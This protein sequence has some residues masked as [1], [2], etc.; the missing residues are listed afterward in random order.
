MPSLPIQH[1][2]VAGLFEPLHLW[3]RDFE[4][5]PTAP[6]LINKLASLKA[7]KSNH[8]DLLTSIYDVLANSYK[9]DNKATDQSIESHAHACYQYEIG[10]LDISKDVLCAMPI[11]LEAGMSDIVIGQD[12]VD[13]LTADEQR[14]FLQL[15]NGHFNQD[16]WEF[17]VSDKGNWFL[18]LPKNTKPNETI[19]IQDALGASLRGLVEGNEDIQWSQQLN[20]LQMLLF[21]S[22]TNQQREQNRQRTISSFWLWD[23]NITPVSISNT[24]KSHLE[25]MVG[26]GYEGQ[27]IANTYHIDWNADI[28]YEGSQKTGS[29]VYIYNDL[30]LLASRNDLEGWQQKLS[31]IEQSLVALLDNDAMHTI[32]YGGRALSW[33]SLDK[34]KWRFFSRRKKTLLELI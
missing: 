8:Q 31:E 34:N 20:E 15:L 23:V 19:P 24:S 10:E 18:L 13:D 7:R 2:F 16:G 21:S 4:F 26:G 12:P 14:Q 11:E 30:Q 17:V 1:V 29:G 3:Q 5:T 6:L 32:I 22:Q 9:G 25:F 27:V 33:S 28:A